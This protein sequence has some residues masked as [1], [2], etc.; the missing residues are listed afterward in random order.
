MRVRFNQTAAAALGGDGRLPSGSSFPN[1]SLVVKE[2]YDTQ[3][4][5]IALYAIMMKDSTD[6]NAGANWLWAEIKPDSKVAVS[7]TDKGS[8]CTGCHGSTP[9]RDY[10]RIFDLF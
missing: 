9:N 5:S 10:L 8:G 4:G 6:G 1:G 7:V 3:N 2:L